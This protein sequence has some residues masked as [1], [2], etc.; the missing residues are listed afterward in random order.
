MLNPLK[1]IL[2]ESKQE[3]ARK[4]PE[5]RNA[6]GHQFCHIKI[7]FTLMMNI[8]ENTGIDAQANE[9]NHDKLTVLNQ[10]TRI[11]IVKCPGTVYEIISGGRDGKAHG[12]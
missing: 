3:I 1:R 11:I 8:I 2:T 7:L 9:G 6:C 5:Y 12:V 4:I 10:Y